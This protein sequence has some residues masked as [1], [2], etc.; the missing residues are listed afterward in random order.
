MQQTLKTIA[1]KDIQTTLKNPRSELEED[2][3]LRG[4]AASLGERPENLVSPPTVEEMGGGQYR[5]LT[6][7]RRVQAAL[8]AGWSEILC[9]VRPSMAPEEAHRLRLVE[10]LHRKSLHPLDR[11]VALKI[12]WLFA[13]ASKMELAQE[14][15]KILDQEQSPQES[16]KQLTTLLAE[17]DFVPTHPEITWDE[18]LDQIGVELSKA[19][20]KKLLQILNIDADVQQRA[21]ETEITEAALRSLGQLEPEQQAVVMDEIEQDPDMARKVR[22]ISHAVRGHDYEL[23]E[24]IAEAKGFVTPQEQEHH[25][26]PDEGDD[27]LNDQ[28][29]D[30]VLAWLDAATQAQEASKRL[31]ELLGGRSPRELSTPWADYAIEATS[32]IQEAVAP[33]TD[34]Q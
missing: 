3:D 11:A 21:R 19:R 5:I 13:N 34:P 14:A 10:N 16:L 6:G 32:M 27:L 23:D 9:L 33:F 29:M 4:L 26:A 17:H 1:L 28:T 24:A 30:T 25:Y 12:E 20:R 15:R 31:S 8:L 2:D 22:R 7:E 18:V